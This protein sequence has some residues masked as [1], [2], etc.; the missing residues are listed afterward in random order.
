MHIVAYRQYYCVHVIQVS[1]RSGTTV[2]VSLVLVAIHDLVVRT[3]RRGFSLKSGTRASV[4]AAA[5]LGSARHAVVGAD[6]LVEVLPRER[7]G[8]DSLEAANLFSTS[9][10]DTWLA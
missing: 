6:G 8:R 5:T 1:Q 7:K 9:N 2:T 10:T 4:H 3:H